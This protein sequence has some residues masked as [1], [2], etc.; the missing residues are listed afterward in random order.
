MALSQEVRDA[1]HELNSATGE[2][3]ADILNRILGQYLGW[4]L[5]V[6][7]GCLVDR[8]GNRTDSFASVVYATSESGAAAAPNEILADNAGVVIDAGESL[9]LEKF[10]ASYR[11]IAQAKSLKK[12]AAPRLEGIPITTTT[13][14]I[15]FALRSTIPLEDIA[16]ELARLNA[17]TPSREWPDMVVASAGVINYAVQFP[18]ESVNGDFLPPAEGASA[19][20]TAPLYVVIVMRPTGVYTFNRM[21][22]FLIAHLGIFSPGSSLAD[23]TQILED[24]PKQAVTISGFQYNLSG[25]LLPV[26]RQFYDDRYLPPLPMRIEDQAGKLLCTLQFL[27]WQDGGTILLRGELLLDGLLTFLGQEVLQRA[28]VVRRGNLQI[29]YVLPITQAHF[30]QMLTRIQRQSNMVV[31]PPQTNFVVQKYSDEGSRS[32]FM[33]RLL[34][35]TMRLRDVVVPDST[36]REAFDKSYEVVFSSLVNARTAAQ[37]IIRVW[38]EHAQKVASGEVARLEGR[39]M[40]INE[41][42]DTELKKEVESFLNAAVRAL[43]DGMQRVANETGVDIGFLF[44]KQEAFEARL[45]ALEATNPILAK[46]LRQ[47]RTW[48]ERLIECRN[49]VEHEGWILPRVTYSNTGSNIR[50]GEPAISGQGLTEFVRFIFDRLACFVEEVT[51]HCLQR[52]MPVGITIT[53]IPFAQRLAEAPERFTVTMTSGGLTEWQITF[54]QSSFEQT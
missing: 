44:Q 27:P 25:D 32:P 15:I 45:T 50:A 54:H 12:S 22:A 9:D 42:I 7:S 39:T 30:N 48:S 40:H 14:G 46:Y 43:K 49:A 10:R 3:L 53:E 2:S 8:H 36:K 5:K 1:G 6:T 51:V 35:G 18:G 4:P 47:T 37:K 13:L 52:M 28:G 29:S 34:M 11:R 41:S 16:E 21:L 19:A 24:V 23:W 31:R 33:A 26:P 17:Q 38:E 20:F